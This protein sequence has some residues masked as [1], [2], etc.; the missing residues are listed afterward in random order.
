M[1]KG[2]TKAGLGLGWVGLGFFFDKWKVV[3][4]LSFSHGLEMSRAIREDDVEDRELTEARA[5]HIR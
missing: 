2:P 5:S 1:Y 3:A 4:V